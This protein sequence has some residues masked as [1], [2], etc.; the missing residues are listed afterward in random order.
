MAKQLP[1]AQEGV[2]AKKFW[3]RWKWIGLAVYAAALLMANLQAAMRNQLLAVQHDSPAA[4]ENSLAKVMTHLNHQIYLNSPA[5]KYATLFLSRYNAETRRLYYCNAGH[6]PP[7]LL[8]ERG[9]QILEA[10]G[11]VVGLFPEAAYE[12]RSVELEPG[13]LIAIF[14]DGVTEAVNKDDEEFGEERLLEA[15]TQARAHAPE[16]IYRFVIGCVR[17]WQGDLPQHDDITLI[18]A[19]AG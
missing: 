3:R 18:I 15:L 16:G 13:A 1:D 9:T 12:A 11:M 19:K 8:N 5:E 7:I 14:T 6:L 17:E 4:I 2:P 10:T